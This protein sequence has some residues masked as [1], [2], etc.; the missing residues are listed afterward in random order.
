MKRGFLLS[1]VIH[2]AVLAVLATKLGA[3]WFPAL[4]AGAFVLAFV[5]G[6]I[7]IHRESDFSRKAVSTH[8]R[9]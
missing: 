3:E 4:V 1:L 9:M 7:K 6:M 5:V 8:N 2:S